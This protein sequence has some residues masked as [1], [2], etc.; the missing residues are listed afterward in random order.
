[1]RVEF[2]GVREVVSKWDGQFVIRLGRVLDLKNY[3]G[4]KGGGGAQ[5]KAG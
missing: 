3:R 5:L 1:M 2:K 4:K